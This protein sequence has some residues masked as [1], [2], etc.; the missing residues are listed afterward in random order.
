MHS[1]WCQT[2]PVGI[3]PV[4]A[5]AQRW[6]THLF[7]DLGPLLALLQQQ[8]GVTGGFIENGL[9]GEE[10]LDRAASIHAGGVE[11]HSTFPCRIFSAS[12]LPSR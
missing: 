12:Y 8:F 4:G 3:P 9:S 6:E 7:Q 5:T 2:A 11:R 1:Y 10:K